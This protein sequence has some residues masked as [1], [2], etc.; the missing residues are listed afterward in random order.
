[1]KVFSI[2][3]ARPQFIKAAVIARALSKKEGIQHEIIHSG[4]HYDESMSDV[5]FEEMDIPMPLYNLNIS[6]GT[7]GAMSG[8][9]M[10]EFDLLFEKE[11]PNLIVVYGDTNTTLAASLS[12]KKMGIKIAHVEA[13]VR[14]FDQYMPEEINRVVTDRLAIL[15]FCCTER[16]IVNLNREGYQ[17]NNDCEIKNVGDVMYDAFLFYRKIMENKELN[18][19]NTG[20][21][22]ILVTLHRPSNVDDTE[23]LRIIIDSLNK[24]SEDF[25][26]VFPIHPRTQSKLMGGAIKPNFTVIQP[27]GYF[28]MLRSLEKADFVITDSG[29]LVREAYFDNKPSLYLLG[30]H[31]WPEIAEVNASL[32]LEVSSQ[33]GFLEAFGQVR[34][35]KVNYNASVFGEGKAGEE[36]ASLIHDLQS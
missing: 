31:V 22:R 27:M 2:V 15:N 29:G 7:H 26:V 36:I 11:T 5:F 35:M 24:L 6:G 28:D 14:N 18:Y 8:R 25:E 9:M 16:A 12:A 20:K 30:E 33:K 32:G 4:Q 34:Q 10:I 3:G 23:R 19:F 21:E 1:M 17:Y 13:G